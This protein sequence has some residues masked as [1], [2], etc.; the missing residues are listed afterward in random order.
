MLFI[1]SLTIVALSLIAHT[2]K[3]N[4]IPKTYIY[5]EGGG[6]VLNGHVKQ[7]ISYY[8]RHIDNWVTDTITFDKNGNRIEELTGDNFLRYKVKYSYKYDKSGRRTETTSEAYSRKGLFI[9]K[10]KRLY[11]YTYNNEGYIIKILSKPDD[12]SSESNLY[13]YNKAGYLVEMKHFFKPGLLFDV[14]KYKYDNNNRLIETEQRSRNGGLEL[15]QTFKYPV[16]DSKDNWTTI[17]TCSEGFLTVP[18][19]VQIHISKRKIIYY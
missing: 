6:D 1:K 16:L 12:P 3:N 13:R 7:I 8:E 4:S 2:Q 19:D 5:S 14:T 9:Y 11:T 18:T 17:E 10:N 15:R